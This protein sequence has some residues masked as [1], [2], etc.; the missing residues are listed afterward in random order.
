[1][2]H[3]FR[4]RRGARA[5]FLAV[6]ALIAGC[7]S[8][9][10]PPPGIPSSPG[11]SGTPVSPAAPASGGTL[12]I[13]F[14]GDIQ[15]F[16][17]AIGYD[18]IAGTAEALLYDRLYDYD[19]KLNIVPYLATAMPTVSADGTQYTIPL[20]NGAQFVK[21]DGTILREITA[22][23]VVYSLNRILNPKLTPTPSPVASAFFGSI[24]GAADVIAGTAETASGI[25]A[26]DPHTIEIDLAHPDPVIM[27]SL[28]SEFASIV[29][30]EFATEDTV[31]FSK[32]PVGS[33]PFLLKAY[34]SGQQAT[35]VRNPHYWQAGQPTLDE[36]DI[37]VGVDD[38]TAL[39]Q[40]EGGSLD[41]LGDG[42]PSGSLTSLLADPARA[43]QIQ[44]NPFVS[45]QYLAMDTQAQ[46]GTPSAP[47]A[48]AQ[49][50]QAFN[51]AI[52][53]AG[54]AKLQHG[55]VS[56]A[57]CIFPPLLPGYDATC[58]PYSYDP[59]KAKQLLAAAGFPNGLPETLPLYT[60]ASDP[61]PQVAQVIQQNLAAIGVQV[62]VVPQSQGVLVST[63]G[64]PHAAPLAYTQWAQ[65]YPDPSDFIDPILTCASAVQGG[66]N[67][68]FFCNPEIDA[69][70]TA[71]RGATDPQ[72]RLQQY[73]AVQKAIM[74]DA[75]WVPISNG[76]WHSMTST[77][78]QNYQGRLVY[79][80]DLRHF[81]VS[82]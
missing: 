3:A 6:T 17:P 24:A 79:Y 80:Y 57:T 44:T 8:S 48:N 77:R 9:S 81:S 25:K 37:H 23:D 71:A 52:D 10:T 61:Y 38:N 31:A 15:S 21:A 58:N 49:V 28:A 34:S 75:P 78:V 7:A 4:R 54:I 66:S 50:R 65:D 76:T 33:G 47:L 72:A 39:Q 40:V 42:I 1:M 22:D 55:A 63:L 16:D 41:L 74:A 5:A 67:V 26:V 14:A 70:A 32:S 53:K 27:N 13:A 45:T 73:Q 11:T 56:V 62:N 20:G 35:F 46:P 51:Y 19:A 69:L 68:A 2:D 43:S 59:E 12:S 18:R 30:K 29:P 82:Q 36:I 64:N 60:E